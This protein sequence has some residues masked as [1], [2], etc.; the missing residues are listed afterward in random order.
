MSVSG[1]KKLVASMIEKYL[2]LLKKKLQ[3]LEWTAVAP[4][5]NLASCVG[6]THH[7]SCKFT[8]SELR[9]LPG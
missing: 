4:V 8:A 1:A 7:C 5:V 2:K 9:E 3:L 6:E